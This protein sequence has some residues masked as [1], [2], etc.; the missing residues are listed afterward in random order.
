VAEEAAE[1]EGSAGA[2]TAGVTTVAGVIITTDL[3]LLRRTAAEEEDM[4]V[5]AAVEVGGVDMAGLLVGGVPLLECM[6]SL[7]WC[8]QQQAGEVPH[9]R[10]RAMEAHLSSSSGSVCW[11]IT[12]RS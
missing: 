2:V 8:T 12:C 10:V 3:R 6:V 4:G 11:G 1:A 9:P 7:V 5:V